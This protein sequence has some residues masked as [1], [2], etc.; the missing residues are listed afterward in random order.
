MTM[1]FKHIALVNIQNGQWTFWDCLPA[2]AANVPWGKIWVNHNAVINFLASGTRWGNSEVSFFSDRLLIPGDQ[3]VGYLI[4]K[5]LVYHCI[6][7]K[8]WKKK[9]LATFFKTCSK[10]KFLY[11]F[12]VFIH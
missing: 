12:N 11:V 4:E 5:P 6:F 2:S 3:I 7:R 10:S 9:D 1:P 8:S